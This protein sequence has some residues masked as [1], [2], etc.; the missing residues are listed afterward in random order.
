MPSTFVPD[1]ALPLPHRLRGGPTTRHSE[2][3]AH[4]SEF[5]STSQIRYDLFRSRNEPELYCALPEDWPTPAFVQSDQWQ[6]AGQI[7]K[8]DPMPLGF[9]RE[10]A[11]I[12]MRLN[13]F[14]L[15]VAFRPISGLRS[16]S[17]DRPALRPVC[18]ARTQSMDGMLSPLENRKNAS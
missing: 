6:V 1:G 7:D 12:G 18:K 8:A 3:L 4:R 5:L 15:F 9:D 13:G 10:A 16:D 14:Y 17:V 11:R 2:A